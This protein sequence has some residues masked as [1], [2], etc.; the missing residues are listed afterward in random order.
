MV[1]RNNFFQIYFDQRRRVIEGIKMGGKPYNEDDFWKYP[2]K[3]IR[4][5]TYLAIDIE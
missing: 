4:F 3:K 2:L 1:L 5:V